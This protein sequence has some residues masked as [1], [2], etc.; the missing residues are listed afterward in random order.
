MTVIC[1]NA[2]HQH[3]SRNR[4]NNINN[5][6]VTATAASIVI[7]GFERINP[8]IVNDIDDKVDSR[9]VKRDITLAIADEEIDVAVVSMFI[10]YVY[11]TQYFYPPHLSNNSTKA[12]VLL[13]L[14]L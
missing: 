6:I 3:H 12:T 1:P 8:I 11:I 7:V 2:S 14:Q 9:D 4:L 5:I 13:H 10:K